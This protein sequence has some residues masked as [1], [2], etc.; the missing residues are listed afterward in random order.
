MCVSSSAMLILR[1]AFIF[2]SATLPHSWSLTHTF[3]S[4]AACLGFWVKRGV[5]HYLLRLQDHKTFEFWIGTNQSCRE[6]F[7]VRRRYSLQEHHYC[8]EVRQQEWPIFDTLI[9]S[10]LPYKI[11]K[12]HKCSL[13]NCHSGG[14]PWNFLNMFERYPSRKKRGTDPRIIYH[15]IREKNFRG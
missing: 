4:V 11:S 12:L 7:C 10:I 3:A 8:Y 1:P 6:W 15:W 14:Y 9:C 5:I 13:H 2:R